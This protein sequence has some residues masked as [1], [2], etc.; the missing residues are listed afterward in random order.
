MNK[1]LSGAVQLLNALT[2]LDEETMDAIVSVGHEV[3]FEAIIAGI[4]QVWA[5]VRGYGEEKAVELL[6]DI[7]D[8]IE[9]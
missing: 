4:V 6:R 7:A 5:E 3:A 2:A 8:T 9:R 1:E